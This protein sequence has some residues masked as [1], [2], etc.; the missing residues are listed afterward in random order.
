[1]SLK[2]E[3]KLDILKLEMG[4]IQNTLDK[5]DDLIFRSRN[6][7]ITL[8][9][10]TIGLSFT[11]PK[12]SPLYALFLAILFWFFEGLMR[13]QYWYK[14][15][16]RYRTIRN[17]VNNNDL[18]NLSVYDMTNKFTNVN[19]K[20]SEKLFRCFLKLEPTMVYILMG[21]SAIVVSFIR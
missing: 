14:Y 6:W 21:I 16:V 18:E 5:Y 7:F 8:W 19:I 12:L 9:A 13:H 2:F 4:L 15:V 10:G 3:D 1:M 11:Q 17:S 20:Q